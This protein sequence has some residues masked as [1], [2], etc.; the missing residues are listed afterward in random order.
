MSG[1]CDELAELRSGLVDGALSPQDRER[2]ITHLL[3]CAECRADVAELRAV[4]DLLGRSARSTPAPTPLSDRLVSIAGDASARPWTKAFDGGS[5]LALPSERHRARVRALLGVIA[6]GAVATAL[7]ITGWFAAPVGSLAAVADPADE[8]QAEFGAAAAEL[9]VTGASLSALMLLDSLPEA[10]RDAADVDRPPARG[11]DEVGEAASLD[12]L[13]R[14]LAAGR[15]TTVDGRQAVLARVEEHR[16]VA[17][18][19][20]IDTR[21][22]Q[23]TLV[24]VF[25]PS[26]S[27]LASSFAPAEVAASGGPSP[28]DLIAHT[29]ALSATSGVEVAGRTASVVEA[30]DRAGHVAKR[31]WVDAATGVLLWQESYDDDGLSTAAG[32]TS[33]E[34]V[35]Y[36]AVPAARTSTRFLT[37]GLASASA[38]R[39]TSS[40]WDCS[41]EVAGLDLLQVSTDTPT[42]PRSVHAVYGD[43]AS[44]VSVLQRHGRLSGAPSGAAWDDGMEVWR[45]K[46]AVRWATWQSGD[47]VYTVTTD[48]ST[49][50]LRQAV[51]AFP[52]E[53]PVRTT[54]LGRVREGWSRI[55]AD[56]KG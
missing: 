9:S 12:L 37:A 55:F 14:A 2:V 17:A 50:L 48:G 22:R 32:F 41:D 38:A 40:G 16:V 42:N 49:K 18:Q 34:V 44:T 39:L 43:G 36:A 26:G 27:V 56:L 5:P 35:P 51:A 11:R 19:V 28:V 1:P 4:R 15:T 13:E 46:G 53:G 30:T 21:S 24:S 52:H 23:G 29:Y 3:G 8:A 10:T 54:T 25:A 45:H 20:G 47:T 33:V 31:W 6:V 7:G